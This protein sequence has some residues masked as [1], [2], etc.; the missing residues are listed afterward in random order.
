MGTPVETTG[1][2]VV[3]RGT[4]GVVDDDGGCVVVGV[5]GGGT[6]R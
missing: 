2:G 5:R 4:K 6:D 1:M 3:R